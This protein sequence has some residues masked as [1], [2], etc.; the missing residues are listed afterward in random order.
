MNYRNVVFLI[1]CSDIE[2]ILGRE[3]TDD[4]KE[5]V[6]HKFTIHDWTE[7][8]EDFLTDYGIHK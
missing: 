3:L 8:V 1:D 4:E 6:T 5:I 2:A 7:I